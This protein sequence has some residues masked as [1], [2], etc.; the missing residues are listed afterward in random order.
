MNSRMA[1]HVNTY[2][3]DVQFQIWDSVILSTQ[4]LR[5]PVVVTCAKTFASRG[6][7]TNLVFD[8]IGDRRADRLNLP[9]YM[10][11]HPIHVSLLKAY[12][13]DSQPSRIRPVSIPYLFADRPEEWEVKAIFRTVGG[14]PIYSI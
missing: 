8:R 11:L 2:R 5:L 10:H 3:R 13:Q 14:P 12:V 1:E 7:G 4:N 9:S 6:T